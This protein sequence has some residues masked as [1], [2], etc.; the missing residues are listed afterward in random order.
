VFPRVRWSC[1]ALD[2]RWPLPCPPVGAGLHAACAGLPVA[3]LSCAPATLSAALIYAPQPS[4]R[5][6]PPEG[7]FLGLSEP[8]LR[9]LS[10]LRR[11]QVSRLAR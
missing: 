7:L 2:H 11:A 10:P 6:L 4:P 9:L 8:L 5:A 1:V 3:A